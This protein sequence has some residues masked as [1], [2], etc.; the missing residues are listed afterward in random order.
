MWSNKPENKLYTYT[1]LLNIL[2]E[3]RIRIL[4]LITEA[5]PQP[6]TNISDTHFSLTEGLCI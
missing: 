4:N 3:A 6:Q 2:N 1:L 5:F